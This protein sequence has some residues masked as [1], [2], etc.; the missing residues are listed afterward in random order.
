MG[1]GFKLFLLF[2]THFLVPF[3]KGT[4]SEVLGITLPARPMA[5]RITKELEKN[6]HLQSRST[7]Q[8]CIF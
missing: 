4:W 3:S 1:E 2:Q 7:G 6:H 5:A 8:P